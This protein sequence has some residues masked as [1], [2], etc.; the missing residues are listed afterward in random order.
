[1]RDQILNDIKRLAN[2]NGGQPLG[3]RAFERETGIRAGAWRG[4]YWARWSDALIEAGFSPNEWQGKLETEFVFQK[5][6]EAC[7]H[8]SRIP[9]VDELK[10]YGRM[11]GRFPYPK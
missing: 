11:H 9:T 7:R 2:A 10:M 3:V 4:I 5:F 8:F 6:I 1:V